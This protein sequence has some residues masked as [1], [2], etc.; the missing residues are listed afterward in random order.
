MRVGNGNRYAVIAALV[1]GVS[2]MY[3]QRCDGAHP[4]CKQCVKSH[5]E[6]QCVYGDA[7]R[8]SRTQQ[9]REKVTTLQDRV[10]ELEYETNDRCVLTNL[11]GCLVK[12]VDSLSQ[13]YLP[14][15]YSPDDDSFSTGGSFPDVLLVSSSTS[16]T[17]SGSPSSSTLEFGSYQ[18]VA[19]TYGHD[20]IDMAS[21]SDEFSPLAGPP[22]MFTQ[23]C[24]WKPKDPFSTENK[25]LLYVFR[26]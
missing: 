20:I 5:R 2:L 8:K 13:P 12:H 10:H 16:T 26:N 14:P 15:F 3:V 18:D 24:Q 25:K 19:Q 4:V 11:R 23:L 1:L 17:S 7:K 22:S 9:L 21:C 6:D